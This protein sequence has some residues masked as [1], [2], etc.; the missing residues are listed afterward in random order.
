MRTKSG[1]EIV[2][3][4]ARGKRQAQMVN[5]FIEREGQVNSTAQIKQHFANLEGK[6]MSDRMVSHLVNTTR[7]G[8]VGSGY[9]IL[10]LGGSTRGYM[11]QKR[12]P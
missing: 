6:H 2:V 11:F 10:T 12:S 1:D 4:I 7:Q 9:E 5:Y 8:L 3:I